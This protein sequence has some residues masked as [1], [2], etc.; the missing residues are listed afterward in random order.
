ME[1]GFSINNI[2][3]GPNLLHPT[4]AFAHIEIRPEDL[5]LSDD[6]FI[7][8]HVRALVRHAKGKF[9]EMQESAAEATAG[10]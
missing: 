9:F 5:L 2:S 4:A 10:T 7:D 1:I 6:E 8:R 3:G